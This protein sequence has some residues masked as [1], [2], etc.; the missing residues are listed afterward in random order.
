MKERRKRKR[1]RLRPR[2]PRFNLRKAMFVLPNLF[3][4]SS[5]GCGFYAILLASDNPGPPQLYQATL[6][7][8]FGLFFD[9][10]DGRVARLT[11]T[12]SEFGVQ[13]DSLADLVTFGV[14]PAVIVYRWG[15]SHMGPLGAFVAFAFV[16]CGT[17]RLARFNVL[18]SRG[19]GGSTAHFIG[20]PIPLAAGVLIALVMFH[21]RAF[22][23][24]LVHEANI[25]VLVGIL[26]YLMV[27]NVRY[28]S[29]KKVRPTRWTVATF[30][31]IVLAFVAIAVVVRPTFALFTFFCAYVGLG[32]V[33][34]VIFFR[35]RRAASANAALTDEPPAAEPPDGEPESQ[36]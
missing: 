34:E 7:V 26:S 16:A 27:S 14:A 21:Q 15:L 25:L 9:M 10:A 22:A 19:N 6:A 30:A 4:I 3:T 23:A 24:P 17:I 13:I 32:L 12:Q 29:F 18:A 36:S 31:I 20:L 1:R 5:V 2:L 33:E 28:R 11:K 8:F 35:R